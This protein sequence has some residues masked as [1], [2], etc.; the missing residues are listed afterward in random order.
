MQRDEV[1]AILAQHRDR[2]TGKAVLRQ[3]RVRCYHKKTFDSSWILPQGKKMSNL[4]EECKKVLAEGYGDRFA[5]LV[6]YGSV[7]RNE[8]LSSSDIDLLVLLKQPFDYFQEL[9]TIVELLYPIQL[10][11]ERL[12]SAK[13]A[14]VDEFERGSLQ[15]YRNAKQEGLSA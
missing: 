2:L 6:L 13:P 10:E 4:L 11:S 15:L 5:G 12:I 3:K 9:R 14:A 1:M 8:A 7:V